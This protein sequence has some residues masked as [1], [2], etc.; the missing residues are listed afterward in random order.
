MWVYEYYLCI[1]FGDE[2][3]IELWGEKLIERLL[4]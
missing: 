3:L 4:T 1:R 2:R